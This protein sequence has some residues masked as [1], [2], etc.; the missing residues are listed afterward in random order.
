MNPTPL[1]AASILSALTAVATFSPLT[2][3]PAQDA[4]DAQAAPAEEAAR[5]AAREV[6][7]L[8]QALEQMATTASLEFQTELRST[9]NAIGMARLAGLG[10]PGQ[11][12]PKVEA[13]GTQQ[14][15]LL[16]YRFGTDDRVIFHG[17]RMIARHGAEPWKLSHGKLV[18]GNPLPFALEPAT[19]AAYLA[20]QDLEI[21]HQEVGERNGRPVVRSTITLT[22]QTAA[23]L[24]LAGGVPD[25]THVS[26]M[27][28]VMVFRGA[29]GGAIVGG[30]PAEGTTID[31]AIAFDPATRHIHEIRGRMIQKN[32]PG[33]AGVVFRVG[34][35]GVPVEED[36]EEEEAAEPAAGAKP[37]FAEG[38]PVRGK[39]ATKDAAVIDFTYA[40]SAHGEAASIELDAGARQLLGLPGK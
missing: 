28:N 35:A 14:D 10:R 8:R 19:L 31:L 18:R 6:A 36:E 27:G 23:D 4:P 21:V 39:K 15:D 2:P 40:F 11:K 25:P 24:L 16:S 1:F 22:G 37:G 17:R 26:G 7:K 3:L 12:Q 20:G 9:G 32:G 38:L 30:G 13:K 34:A 29:M 33:M 5:R